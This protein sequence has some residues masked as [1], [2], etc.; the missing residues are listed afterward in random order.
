MNY[1]NQGV[2]SLNALIVKDTDMLQKYTSPLYN[3]L[4]IAE[5]TLLKITCLNPTKA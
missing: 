1:S 2:N 5:V 4:I 3:A